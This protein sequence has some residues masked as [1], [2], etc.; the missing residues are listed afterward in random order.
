MQ[1]AVGTQKLIQMFLN[2][3]RL[4]TNT[5][6]GHFWEP[7]IMNTYFSKKKNLEEIFKM[8]NLAGKIVKFKV[9]ASTLITSYYG[10]HKITITDAITIRYLIPS[11]TTIKANQLQN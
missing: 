4:F 9:F 1:E 6:Q 3:K 10:V 2:L 7:F 8:S 5:K 11:S